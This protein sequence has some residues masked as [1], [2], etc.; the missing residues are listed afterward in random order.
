M[1]KAIIEVDKKGVVDIKFEGFQGKACDFME[2]NFLQIF[3]KGL[4]MNKT[5]E[6]RKEQ[7]AG[8]MLHV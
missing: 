3:K 5:K 4:D 6:D 7:Q 2:N 1:P 8:D